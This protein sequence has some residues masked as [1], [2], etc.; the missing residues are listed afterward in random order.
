MPQNDRPANAAPDAT[1]SNASTDTQP[2]RSPTPWPHSRA[3]AEVREVIHALR[4][5]HVLTLAQ[6]KE[7][8]WAAIGPSQ[9]S[10]RRFTARSPLVRS[11]SSARIYTRFPNHAVTTPEAENRARLAVRQRHRPAGAGTTMTNNAHVDSRRS[12][13]LVF[14]GAT[15]DLV[16]KQIFPALYAMVKRGALNVPVIGIAYSKWD[17]QQLHTRVATASPKLPAGPTTREPWTA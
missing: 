7:L 5:N 8:C 12:D 3:E 2:S 11:N 10:P 9:T 4:G 15:G 16:H 13:A 1:S 6:I 17:L 14:F